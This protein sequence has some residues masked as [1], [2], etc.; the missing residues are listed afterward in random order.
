M[1]AVDDTIRNLKYSIPL[2]ILE[3]AFLEYADVTHRTI[4]LDERIKNTI[5]IGRVIRDCSQA[6]GVQVNIDVNRCYVTQLEKGEYIID[7]PKE[8]TG[9]RSITNVLSITSNVYYTNLGGLS[10]Y[11][12]SLTTYANKMAN[13]IGTANFQQTARAELIGDNIIYINDPMIIVNRSSIRANVE[14]DQNLT[15]LHPTIMPVFNKLVV[16]ATQSYIHNKLKINLDKGYIYAGYDLSVIREIVDGYSDAEQMYQEHLRNFFIP[17]AIT[18]QREKL[19]RYI[20]SML[21][22]NM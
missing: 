8:L 19:G 15:N 12:N 21:G 18:T 7:V 20:R 9:G 14:Y 5:I 22:N 17:G 1:N 16:L 2:E 4:S 3:I 13:N 11:S 6:E 10:P